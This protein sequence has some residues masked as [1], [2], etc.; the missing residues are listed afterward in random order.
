MWASSN[1]QQ[2]PIN[3][4]NFTSVTTLAPA[5]S[6]FPKNNVNPGTNYTPGTN[7]VPGGVTFSSGEE[8]NGQSDNGYYLNGINT[9]AN[10]G[11]APTFATS[12]EAI[13]DAKV[14]V[15]DFNAA[16]GHDISSLT[17][18]IK[19]GTSAFHGEAFEFIENDI[20]N[21]R[22]PYDKALGLFNKGSLRRNHFVA[23]QA[24]I[25]GPAVSYSIGQGATMISACWGVF[26]WHEFSQTPARS[27]TKLAWM[28]VFFLCGLTAVACAPLIS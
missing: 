27:K 14:Q 5:I 22:N 15:S 18:S 24:H 12:T 10:Y 23:S 16:N 7:D 3:G 17:V 11:A 20:F 4:R 21:S 13:Q 28:F 8:V 9:T 25:V 6:T 19:S 1:F 26:V 2:L